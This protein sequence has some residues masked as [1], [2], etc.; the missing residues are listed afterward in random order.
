MNA[1]HWYI[2][3]YELA[4]MQC[5]NEGL[6]PASLDYSSLVKKGLCKKS[7]SAFVLTKEGKTVIE[8]IQMDI[9]HWNDPEH[10]INN[11]DDPEHYL[12]GDAPETA[13][14]RIEI[15]YGEENGMDDPDYV[16]ILN[17]DSLYPEEDA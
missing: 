13:I 5:L 6:H 16:D 17:A 7:R 3:G 4:A 1:K 8:H 15:V 14:S 11:P 9:E 2:E 10:P 12:F